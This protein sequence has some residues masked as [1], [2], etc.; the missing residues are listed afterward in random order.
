[1]LGDIQIYDEGSF[2]Y[3][4]DVEYAV[5]AGTTASINAGEPVGKALGA[6]AVA[7]MADAT[8]VVATD[9]MA[10]IAASTSTETASAAGTVKVMKLTNGVSFLISPKTAATWDTQAEYDALVGDRIVFDLTAGTWT[11]DAT[12]GATNGLVVLPLNIAKHPGKVRFGI[13]S[14]VNYLA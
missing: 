10:G 14:A 12:D 11:V 3:P 9:F 7:A 5:A 6:A 1:M 4:G 8:P 2:G 13:R